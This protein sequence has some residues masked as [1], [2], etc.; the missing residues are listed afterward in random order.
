MLENG[1]E[2]LIKERGKWDSVAALESAKRLYRYIS[3]EIREQTH[4]SAL[5]LIL[6]H[7][8]FNKNKLLLGAISV[9]A[10]AG[11]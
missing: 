2:W 8:F 10:L 3:R 11:I 7:P 1:G 6:F 9:V 4:C 5:L